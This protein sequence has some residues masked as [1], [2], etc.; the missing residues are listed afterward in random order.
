MGLQNKEHHIPACGGFSPHLG[1]RTIIA[2]RQGGRS[3]ARN[4]TCGI[5]ADSI[6]Y[7]ATRQEQQF[8]VTARVS[9]SMEDSA[10]SVFDS[11]GDL[12]PKRFT[13]R[14]ASSMQRPSTSTTNRIRNTVRKQSWPGCIHCYWCASLSKRASYQV[15]SVYNFVNH[16]NVSSYLQDHG[17]DATDG[18]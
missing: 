15:H 6:L 3:I 11:Q 16:I 13:A 10:E 17:Y 5:L 4:C 18:M 14:E 12:R 2:C 7:I 8:Q 9:V 1:A